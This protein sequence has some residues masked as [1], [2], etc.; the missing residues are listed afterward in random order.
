MKK[1]LFSILLINVN[2][3]E[4]YNL[5]RIDFETISGEYD[6]TIIDDKFYLMGGTIY[7]YY[8]WCAI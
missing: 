4:K 2:A 5:S 7:M 8:K 6:A 3:D 1:V